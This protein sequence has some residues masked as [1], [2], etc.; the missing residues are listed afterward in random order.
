MVFIFLGKFLLIFIPIL[1][2]FVFIKYLEFHNQKEKQGLKLFLLVL[3][4]IYLYLVFL[5]T[6]INS[7]YFWNVPSLDS[8]NLVLF[9]TFGEIS[10]LLNILLFFPFGV[11]IPMIWRE[12]RS[13]N[14]T[15]LLGSLCSL[16]I[17]L[18]QLF[19]GRI[20]DIDDFLMNTLGCVFGYFTWKLFFR[21]L[22]VGK[23]IQ[24]GSRVEGN[25]PIIWILLLLFGYLFLYC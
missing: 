23:N 13:L 10:Y 4:L 7:I 14:R 17:E 18:L 6:G 19:C 11:F 16:A 24:E 9:D 1:L 8:V 21:R 20:T 3:F 2:Y 25:S 5:V 12:Y 22:S 15:V